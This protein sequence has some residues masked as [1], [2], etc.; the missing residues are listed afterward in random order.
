[1]GALLVAAV[2]LVFGQTRGFEF[3]NFDDDAVVYETPAVTRGLEA[4][5]VPWAFTRPV[6]GHWAPLT[7]LSHMAACEAFGLWAGGH[8]LVNVALHAGAVVALWLALRALTGAFWRPALVAA[9]FAIHPLRVE[10]VAWITERKDVLSGLFFMLTLAAYA[11]WVRLRGPSS[12][13]IPSSPSSPMSPSTWLAYAGVLLFF[14]LGLMAKAMLVTLPFVLLLLDYWPL[15][16]LGRRAL[17]EKIPLFALAAAS[18]AAAVFANRNSI[19]PMAALGLEWRVGNALVAY[20]MYLVQT[21]WPAGLA[22]FYPHPSLK[23]PLWQPA[24]AVLALAALSAGA[25]LQRRERPWLLMGWLWYLGV[26][27]PVIGLVQSG[28]LSRA[29]RYMYLP[30]IGLAL[31]A[32]WGGAELAA[33]WR[34]P[35]AAQAAGAAGLVLLWMG[36]A[37]RQTGSWQ[38]S[39]TLWT[40]ALASTAPSAQAHVNF[41]TALAGQGRRAEVVAHLERALA[42]D[43]AYPLAHGELGNQR[44]AEG[45]VDEAIAHFRQA[46]AGEPG[47]AGLRINLG[48]ALLAK[49]DAEGA[50]AEYR[51]ALETEPDFAQ[52]HYA[53]GLV[54]FRRGQAAEARA[55]WEKALAQWPDYPE[56]HN[57][58]GYVLFQMGRTDEALGHY[59]RALALKPGYADAQSNL[60]EALNRAG[61]GAEARAHYEQWLAAAP[62]NASAMQGLAWLLATAPDAALRDGARARALAQ[63]ASRLT[64]G[65]PVVLGT[66]AAAQAERGDFAAAAATAAQASERAAAQGHAALAESLRGQRALYEQGRAFRDR[67]CCP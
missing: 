22:V 52:A 51:R 18:C 9:A 44:Q 34:V 45:K 39:E 57:N 66:L 11:R 56:A 54:A 32:V 29:D 55:L 5:S 17:L 23:L 26:L 19:L 60:G 13:S 61:R 15:R 50:V 24:L 33:R 6:L 7:T 31:A 48:N 30:G 20:A 37:H 41:A 4:G 28:A 63:E 25:W 35:R 49:G 2:W 16:R 14:T 10:S 53:L 1:M 47:K 36:L 46:L 59:R 43:P 67:D 40:R 58:L 3:V 8:H 62:G 38:N 64:G 65:H 27:V 12:P 21:A 42:L